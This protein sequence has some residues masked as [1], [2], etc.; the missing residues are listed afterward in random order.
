MVINIFSDNILFLE[1]LS[2]QIRIN[3]PDSIVETEKLSEKADVLMLDE[4]YSNM[5]QILKQSKDIPIVLFSAKG[6]IS[7]IADLVIK[8]PFS[9][10]SF[11]DALKNNKLLPN[12]RHKECLLFKEY[13][14]Y[15]V[16]KEI[17]SSITQKNT[18]LT[19]KEIN[20]I[21]YLYQMAPQ[22]VSKEQLLENVWGYSA[23]ATTHT[24]ETHIYRLRQKV[25]MGGASQLIITENNGY[26]LNI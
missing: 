3:V 11:I 4:H 8:K 18:K 13:C 26:R 7:D 6:E 24:V 25:E 15:P 10:N 16:K 21:K 23:E 22:I 2:Q 17:F 20:I 1:D 19:E 5:P 14:V 12:V 9:L